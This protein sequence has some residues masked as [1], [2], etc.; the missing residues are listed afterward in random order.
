MPER[1][2]CQSPGRIFEPSSR[3]RARGALLPRWALVAIAATAT[4]AAW[5][6]LSYPATAAAHEAGVASDRGTPSVRHGRS[7]IHTAAL[8]GRPG[9]RGRHRKRCY[10]P[11]EARVQFRGDDGPGPVFSPAFYAL[12]MTLETS[13]DEGIDPLTLQVP[14]AIEKVCGIPR[15]FARQARRLGGNDGIALVRPETSVVDHGA[16]VQG[17]AVIQAFEEA[18]TARVRAQLVTADAWGQDEDGNTIPTF[19]SRWIKITD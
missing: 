2:R 6:G 14:I 15:R 1:S 10:Q 18:D 16:L 4:L 13:V 3:P 7:A 12:R 5:A 8:G 11:R 17:E 19:S 9:H